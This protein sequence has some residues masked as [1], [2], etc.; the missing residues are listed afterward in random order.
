MTKNRVSAVIC[1]AGRGERAGFKC[2]KL[3][4]PLHG[5]PALYHTLKQFD[6]P[7]I[8]E[9]IVASS[10]FDFGQISALCAPF[11]YKVAI[12]GETR[13]QSVKNALKEV[14]GEIVLIH[15]GARPYVTREIILGCIDSV[16]KFGNGICSVKAV[17]TA[18]Y[19][20]YGLISERLDRQSMYRVQT[21]QGF[22]TDD[23]KRAYDLAG[24]GE[25]TDDSAVFCEFIGEARLC[26]GSYANVKL[27]YKSDFGG[28]YAPPNAITDGAAK[29]GFGVD[30]HA[31]GEG[32][33]VT[34]AGV[35]IPC[36]RR[37]IAHSD[38][39]AVIHAVM[40]ALLSAAGLKD[41][42]HYFPDTDEKY[43][44]ADSGELLKEVIK[45]ISDAGYAPINLSVTIQAEKPRLAPYIDEMKE[46]LGALTGL[47]PQ[48][49]AVAAGTC[50]G[51]GFV[52]EGLGVAAYCAALLKKEG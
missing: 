17:D 41:I 36:D 7:E 18:V 5:A 15:D 45:I 23:I 33:G 4:A 29:V 2:N 21:P 20:Q 16:E 6:I 43:A 27:T 47:T 34:L 48:N 49:V 40:D 13:T 11:G 50:E 46:K 28:T 25:Y 3:L 42:G 14:T 19:G 37:L 9:V 22:F 51:L 30:V 38:G 31:F 35:K 12:G 39:D 1:A 52:G 8:D 10:E 24:N 44:G 32:D 26:E